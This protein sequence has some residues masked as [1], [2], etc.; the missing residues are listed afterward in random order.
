MPA[1]C[2]HC[3][4]RIETGQSAL[5]DHRNDPYHDHC[6]LAKAGQDLPKDEPK[7]NWQAPTEPIT[8]DQ[9]RSYR[10]RN[11]LSRLQLAALLLALTPEQETMIRQAVS[12][13]QLIRYWETGLH[14]P[15]NQ[16]A[17]TLHR[18]LTMPDET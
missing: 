15:S 3:G 4:K 10:E 17:T 1:N 8:A 13:E 7:R 2:T 16:H 9:I 14:A 12:L 6:Y 18:I 5:L 11:G